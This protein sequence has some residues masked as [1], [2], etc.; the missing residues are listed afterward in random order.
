MTIRVFPSVPHGTVTVPASKSMAHRAI[1]CA[2]LAKGTSILRNVT[3]SKDIAATVRGMEAL[4]AVISRIGEN[5]LQVEGTSL[6]QGSATYSVDC[7][8]S[9]STL[10]FLIPLSSLTGREACFTG[11]GRLLERPQQVYRDIFREQGL[12][13]SHTG[14]QIRICGSLRPGNF[15]LRGDVSSQFITGLLFALP[16]LEGNS[17][18]R[19]QPPFESRSYVELTLETMKKFGVSA[20]FS[21]S[22]TL[23]IPGRQSYRSCDTVIEGDYSQAAFF[24]VLGSIRGEVVCDGL[25]ADTRQGDATILDILEEFGSRGVPCGSGFRFRESL[26]TGRKID[27]GDCPDLG[28][29]LTV[30]GAY[31]RGNTLIRNTARLK[32]KES[33]RGA[34]MEEELSRLGVAVRSGENDI[35]ISGTRLFSPAADTLVS[36]HN[37][38]RIAMSLAVFA[39]CGEKPVCISGAESVE[40]SYPEFWNDLK[41]AGIRWEVAEE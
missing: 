26:L 5:A 8:E 14:N 16:M 12:E 20:A 34:V 37:D 35:I 38:H 36:A 15:C 29:I 6:F 2:C 10:R 9:G 33:D 31:S 19:I 3:W 25:R 41:A 1:I 24:A 21:D 4:G 13:F 32:I 23:R 27:L 7:C 40:K 22:L 17:E 18:I 28:P 39:A 30:L 11:Q